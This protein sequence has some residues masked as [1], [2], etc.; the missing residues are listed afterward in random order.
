MK[1]IFFLVGAC[2]GLAGPALAQKANTNAQRELVLAHNGKTNY[3]IT[4]AADAIPAEN[5]AALQLQKY[6]QQV[7]GARFPIQAEKETAGDRPQILVGAGQRVKLLLPEQNWAALGQ[8]GIVLKSNGNKLILAGGR[9]RG[10]LYA[11][12]E[13]L[14]NSVGCRWWT[15]SAQTIPRRQTLKVAPQNTVYVPPFRYREAYTNDVKN[16]MV[17]ATI[18]RNNGQHQTQGPEWGGHYNLL[19]WVHTFSDLLPLEKH[20]KAHPEWYSDPANGN[21]PCTAQ[22]AMPA[23]NATQPDLTNPE[24][25]EEISNTALSWIDQ[26]PNAGYISISHNDGAGFCVTPESAALMESEGSESGVLLKF[27]NAV[28]ARIREKYPDVLVET[29]AYGPSIKP[30]KTIR[31]A[32]N[33]II[34]FAPFHR[35]FGHPFESASNDGIRE[36]FTNWEKISSHLFMWNYTTNFSTTMYPHPNWDGLAKDLRYFAA[37]K[38]TGIFQQGDDYTN[39][40]GDFVQLRTWL[41]GKLMWNPNLDQDKLIT[42]FTDGYYGPA[43]PFMRDYLYAVLKAFRASKHGL[44]TVNSDITFF[45]LDLTNQSIRLFQ[46]AAAAAKGDQVLEDRVAKSR[47]SFD[48]ALLH[49]YKFLKKTATAQGREFLGPQDPEAALKEF[50]ETTRKLGIPNMG[51]AGFSEDFDKAKVVLHMPVTTAPLPEFAR[52]YPP[53]DVIDL[54]ESEYYLHNQ[55]NLTDAVN[56]AG[57]SDGRAA[58]VVG[59]TQEWAIQVPLGKALDGPGR[60]HMY[61]MARAE[62]EAG[63]EAETGGSAFS[64]AAY[65]Q[66]AGESYGGASVPL[67]ALTSPNYQRVDLGLQ[68]LNPGMYVWIAPTKNPLVKKIYID[69]LILI[70]QKDDDGAVAP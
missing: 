66:N 70:R 19:G 12:Y 36:I 1:R 68:N 28:S 2:L 30:P 69:R 56:D 50:M 17:F 44:S 47:L 62:T 26:N 39:G 63:T 52:A 25:L 33:V 4:L 49:R 10:S 14:E 13:F 22:S 55:G 45:D 54:Q 8:D 38:V 27:V 15:P 61:A 60:W 59:N 7:T 67:S 23:Y 51:V 64:S 35:D 65:D 31:P 53:E 42:E 43:A 5:T 29:L 34:R 6:L 11:V 24:V 57:A 16:D 46:Q 40:L 18:L 32:E 20:F 9:A 37:H 21:K 48:T 3:V 58:W 41:M